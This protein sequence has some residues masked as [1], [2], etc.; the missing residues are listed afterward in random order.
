MERL[1]NMNVSGNGQI[2]EGKYNN[3]KISGSGVV[4]GSIES[5]SIV[6][7]GSGDFLGYV[8]SKD[9]RVSGSCNYRKDVKGGF[10]K[11]SGSLNCY[12]LVHLDEGLKVSGNSKIYGSLYGKDIRISGNIDI[13]KGATFNTMTTSGVV[14]IKGDCEGNDFKSSGKINIDGLLS[15][16]KIE[17]SPHRKSFIK[18]IGG[19][20]IIIKNYHSKIPWPILI[21]FGGEKKVK[22]NLIEGDKITLSSTECSLV[23]GENIVI[24]EGCKIDCIEYTK[25]LEIDDKSKVLKIIKIE[26]KEELDLEK[27]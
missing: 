11:V 15:A 8:D 6:V 24:E 25:S 13:G 23:R 19:E 10:L 27:Y 20:E 3:V 17:I 1:N 5:N 26:N 16:D 12:G 2:P 9:I 14:N 22:S 21:T 7:S 18:E 4:N